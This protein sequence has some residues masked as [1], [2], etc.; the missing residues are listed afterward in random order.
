M[1]ASTIGAGHK[2][3]PL[4]MSFTQGG[5][6]FGNTFGGGQTMG[7][8]TMGNTGKVAPESPL[9][10]SAGAALAATTGAKLI[11]SARENMEEMRLHGKY[12]VKLWQFQEFL[13]QEK[14][15]RVACS[16]LPFTIVLWFV[17]FWL[18]STHTD[19]SASY[20]TRLAIG[21]EFATA[22]VTRNVVGQYGSDPG[23]N[24]RAFNLE[25]LNDRQEL[26]LWMKYVLAPTISQDT[27]GGVVS[28]YNKLA[29]GVRVVQRRAKSAT[30]DAPKEI[31]D[32]L[33]SGVT[34]HAT[35]SSD[36]DYSTRV[37]KLAPT[38]KESFDKAFVGGSMMTAE[39]T[40]NFV[41]WVMSDRN[42]LDNMRRVDSLIHGNWLDEDSLDVMIQG[43]FYNGNTEMYAFMSV[44]VE[45]TKAGTLRI[46]NDVRTVKSDLYPTSME[47]LPDVVFFTLFLILLMQEI[48]QIQEDYREGF[49]W[50]YLLD[51]WNFLD[52]LV[53]VT[54][55]SIL[56]SYWF[57][58]IWLLN[59]EKMIKAL[60]E[61]PEE[62]P[63]ELIKP[64]VYNIV[65]WA[66]LSYQEK[67]RD[68]ID[69]LEDLVAF[70][71]W[72]DLLLFWFNILNM[73]RFFK[74][75]R[76]Q[77]RISVLL[78]TFNNASIDFMHYLMIFAVVFFNYATAGLAMYGVYIEEF[79]TF[80]RAIEA[81]FGMLFGEMR[82][83]S[84]YEIS[85]S[86]SVVFFWSF[87]IALPFLLIN[88][89]L[90]LVIENFLFVK[91]VCGDGGKGIFDQISDYIDNL[92]WAYSYEGAKKSAPIDTLLM[93]CVLA[94]DPEDTKN[95]VAARERGLWGFK[96]DRFRN[97]NKSLLAERE[98]TV[99][100]L[101]ANGCDELNAHRLLKRCREQLLSER[102]V[103]SEFE[104]LVKTLEN[105]FTRVQLRMNRLRGNFVQMEGDAM[106]LLEVSYEKLARVSAWLRSIRV[107][108][109]LPEGW[110]E[111]FDEKND[112]IYYQHEV[113]GRVVWAL[114]KDALKQRKEKRTLRSVVHKVTAGQLLKKGDLLRATLALKDAG[115]EEA[116]AAEREEE[117]M[118]R[119]E[120]SPVTGHSKGGESPGGGGHAENSAN[121]GSPPSGGASPS[122]PAEPPA[123]GNSPTAG[124]GSQSQGEANSPGSDRAGGG[125]ESADASK[126]EPPPPEE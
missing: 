61:A 39:P 91:K 53:I 115:K 123:G 89:L 103:F 66:N 58:Y 107:Q 65:L 92:R 86:I 95:A 25:T 80:S 35:V 69:W 110:T 42:V 44:E 28:S 3:D 102:H 113:T 38:G 21:S 78:E 94:Q 7:S 26:N 1:E 73:L 118:I 90:A 124:G 55:A 85:P 40:Y 41:A 5:S 59:L 46:T 109:D 112:K 9:G 57:S 6:T 116:Q 34:C 72:A 19:V 43:V 83:N 30:C 27:T 51:K 17:F 64:N 77:P 15:L 126:G 60:G 62:I 111:K 122:G 82:F 96:I 119:G 100:Y 79:S 45:F 56:L 4:D 97:L 105:E 22:N 54:S 13:M 29:G 48:Q 33:L 87:M 49:I 50:N 71:V 63:S 18:S 108:Q 98:V 37:P 125:Q 67:V 11:A 120:I 75:F 117:A 8:T 31:A 14:G 99:D 68:I 104:Y 88:M 10:E 81:L 16:T 76:G 114:P 84:M 12:G 20:Q 106:N 24:F 101:V 74:G 121:P 47:V 70:K 2:P 32:N 36:D 93:K 23:I 52:W